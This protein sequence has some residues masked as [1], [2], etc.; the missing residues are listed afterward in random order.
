MLDVFVKAILR[1]TNHR[2]LPNNFIK[3]MAKLRQ[4]SI[5]GLIHKHH[6][7]DFF[8][9]Y[10]GHPKWALTQL[11]G[12]TDLFMLQDG[13]AASKECDL[14]HQL[15]LN[16][17]EEQ[18]GAFK[19]RC[20]TKGL[21]QRSC[22]SASAPSPLS[23]RETQR[24]ASGSHMTFLFKEEGTMPSQKRTRWCALTNSWS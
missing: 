6:E 5:T 15:L 8:N 22:C 18:I 20:I 16:R 7:M 17:M 23:Y 4:P 21:T 12:I 2:P 13:N 9:T 1:L 11:Q 3:Q 14:F 19:D 24:A 10:N